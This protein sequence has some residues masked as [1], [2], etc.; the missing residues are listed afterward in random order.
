MPRY[1]RLRPPLPRRDCALDGR[2]IVVTVV[3]G[4][5]DGDGKRARIGI[6]TGADAEGAF[7]LCGIV[8]AGQ[9][10]S[11]RVFVLDAVVELLLHRPVVDGVD[12]V[13]V[14]AEGRAEGRGRLEARQRGHGRQR[15]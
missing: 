10:R 9:D 14:V 12:E 8:R 7:R 1:S 2:A 5:K 6:A 3:L 13:I 4:D 15:P 11:S